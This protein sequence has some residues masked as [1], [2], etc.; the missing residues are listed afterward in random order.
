MAVDVE[1]LY[2][3]YG[4][5]VLRRCRSLLR[6]DDRALD[7]MQDVFVQVLRHEAR[8]SAEAPAG[9]LLRM[10]T[11]VCLNLI[12]RNRRKPE[13]PKEELLLRIASDDRL[14]SRSI[15]RAALSRL[16]GKEQESTRTMAVMHLVDGLTL[17]EV[18]REVGLSVS[19]VRK[20]LRTLKERA[21]AMEEAA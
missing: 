18:A 5:M 19:G 3:R 10:A 15:A 7:A 9:L 2:E 6:D 14:E 12:R 21:V 20:R 16:F 1:E 8:L 13:D 4:P 11:N 17:E